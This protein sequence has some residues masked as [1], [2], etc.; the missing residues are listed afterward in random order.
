MLHL[1]DATSFDLFVLLGFVSA[2]SGKGLHAAHPNR[3][4]KEKHGPNYFVV[5][6]GNSRLIDHLGVLG[7]VSQRSFVTSFGTPFDSRQARCLFGRL[8]DLK[9]NLDWFGWVISGGLSP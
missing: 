4:L 2:F 3:T 1:V 8:R 9:V 7:V 5:H 6:R